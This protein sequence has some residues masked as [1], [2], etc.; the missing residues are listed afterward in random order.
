MARRPVRQEVIDSRELD[1]AGSP[2]SKLERGRL[3][4]EIGVL[5]SSPAIDS[6]STSRGGDC[7]S[8][9]SGSS[10]RDEDLFL[11]FVDASRFF[12]HRDDSAAAPLRT[13]TSRR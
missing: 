12:G 13:R 4:K 9:F 7:R 5:L 10:P 8:D 3:P 6:V 2:D 1:D 11:D